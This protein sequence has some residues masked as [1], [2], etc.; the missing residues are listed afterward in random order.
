MVYLC[1]AFIALHLILVKALSKRKPIHDA[2]DERQAH[3]SAS[4][5]STPYNTFYKKQKLFLYQNRNVERPRVRLW[6]NSDCMSMLHDVPWRLWTFPNC[7][8]RQE[9]QGWGSACSSVHLSHL[10][11]AK[12]PLHVNSMD[13]AKQIKFGLHVLMIVWW[14]A[15]VPDRRPQG[16]PVRPLM[17]SDVPAANSS[18]VPEKRAL[19]ISDVCWGAC[20]TFAHACVPVS[21]TV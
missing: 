12:L 2:K 20:L 11:M 8:V 21:H 10:V 9:K 6:K 15:N 17:C 1:L 4:S 5:G 13:S 19:C 7:A 3:H 16:H 18:T 14:I